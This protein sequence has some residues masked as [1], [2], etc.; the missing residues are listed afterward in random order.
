MKREIDNL[1]SALSEA[2]SSL[3][4]ILAILAIRFDRKVLKRYLN[5]ET[6][7]YRLWHRSNVSN[8]QN[9]LNRQKSISNA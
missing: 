7:L 5:I 8:V 3:L 1:I 6:P 2:L 4:A 9:M